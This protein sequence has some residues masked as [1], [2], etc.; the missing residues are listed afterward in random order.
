MCLPL[1][2]PSLRN[3]GT[4]KVARPAR[5]PLAPQ[6]RASARM[7]SAS[8]LEQNHFEPLMRHVPSSAFVAAHSL[9]R[10][11]AAA[12]DLGHEHAASPG[13]GEVHGGE[14]GEE[15]LADVGRGMAVHEA[16]GA[17]GHADAAGEAGVALVEQVEE[18][19]LDDGRDVAGAGVLRLVGPAEAEEAVVPEVA[20]VIEV[21]LVVDDVVGF[22]APG[23]V[24]LEAGRVLVGELG[25]GGRCAGP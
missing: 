16:G 11:V 4:R 19:G 24:L 22:V 12:A 6:G 10:E 13:L 5:P 20:L 21:A 7:A 1:R 3:F 2:L 17:R 14:V 25:R 8:R 9:R 23:V 18:A 15:E